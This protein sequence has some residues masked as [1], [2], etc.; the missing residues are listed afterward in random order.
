MKTYGYMRAHDIQNF[1]IEE[2]NIKTAEPGSLD[3]IVRVKA[4]SFNPVDTKIR[5]VRSSE[6]EQPQILGWDAS[7]IIEELGSEVT[8]FSKGDEVFYAGDLTRPGSYSELQAVDYRLIAKKPVSISHN[9]AAALPLTSITAWEALF[10]RGFEY[11]AETKVLIIG[12]AGGVGS[13]ATQLLKA[14]TPATVIVTASREETQDWCGSMGAD[15]V[16]GRDIEKDLIEKG[17]DQVDIVF[18][19]THTDQYLDVIQSILRPFGSLVL[20]DD[21]EKLD[22]VSFKVK[23]LSVHWEL[24]FTKSMFGY[25]PEQQGQFF[26]KLAT[27]VDQ[28]K[29]KSTINMTLPNSIDSI[30]KA[31]KLLES[32][33]SIGKIVM[34]R[35]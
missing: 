5:E 30:R 18:S 22:I 6:D 1:S 17:I 19:T 35:S 31:H 33:K 24:M 9:E 15:Y 12:G 27:L 20:I 13:M 4:I 29:V 21:P 8:S 2:M 14:L 25:H 16:I 3:V 34:E 28:G 26:A 10:E 11:T 7:G 32:G 23:A